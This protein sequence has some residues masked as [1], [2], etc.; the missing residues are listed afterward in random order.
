MTSLQG[1]VALVTGGS[2]GIGAA[3]STRLASQGASVALTYNT[4]EERAKG[5]VAG[6]ESEGGSA[7]AVRADVAEPEQVVAAVDHA[8]D[9]FGRLDILVNNA[10]IFT[11]GDIDDFTL[12]DYER[13]MA[14]HVRGVFVATQAAARRMTD[15]GRIISIGSNL[16]ERAPGPG[17][18]LYSMSKA[19]LVGFTRG[20]ARDLGPRGIAATV[21]H[22]GSTDTD[23]NPADGPGADDQ[24]YLTALGRYNTADE[25]AATVAYLA[26]PGG[27][28]ITGSAITV[29][30]GANA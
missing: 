28:T 6:I 30:G 27:A 23:M 9:A 20:V 14:V 5:V 17:T 1:K 16:A 29:D 18:S 12:A 25:V 13:I 19:A 15:G 22:P 2:R 8:V 3:I 11:Y 26:G 7:V 24:R 21:V 10:G 4:A